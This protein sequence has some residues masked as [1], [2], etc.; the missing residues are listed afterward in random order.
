MC[1][2]VNLHLFVKQNGMFT[3]KRLQLVS[4]VFTA[5]GIYSWFITIRSERKALSLSQITG[6]GSTEYIAKTTAAGKWSSSE[7]PES[8][9]KE[10]EGKSSVSASTSTVS[11]ISTATT[12]NLEYQTILSKVNSGQQLT[13][14]ELAILKEKNPAAYARAIRT[15]SDQAVASP[16]LDNYR[17]YETVL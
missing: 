3:V 4:V 9:S 10:S 16:S 13:S 8:S 15:E 6:V 11:A 14:A 12:D 1:T 5:C 17:G 2:Q 7:K